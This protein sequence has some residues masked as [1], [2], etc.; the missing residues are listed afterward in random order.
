MKLSSRLIAILLGELYL[1]GFGTSNPGALLNV[2]IIEKDG[3]D[4]AMEYRGSG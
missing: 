1:S 3:F 4:L 2:A